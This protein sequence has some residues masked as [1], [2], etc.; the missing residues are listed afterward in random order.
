MITSAG[1]SDPIKS[2]LLF[3]IAT[4]ASKHIVLNF[5]YD[6]GY[7]AAGHSNFGFITVLRKLAR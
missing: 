7:R 1:L 4:F 6:F 5:G 3:R 2:F